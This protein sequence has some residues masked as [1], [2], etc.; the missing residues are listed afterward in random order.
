VQ[1]QLLKDKPGSYI[2]LVD[3]LARLEKSQA[4]RVKAEA[5]RDMVE[6]QRQRADQA[7]KKLKLEREK[8][9]VRTAELF[10]KFYEDKRA[11]EIAEGKGAKTVKMEKLRQLMFPDLEPLDPTPI[12]PT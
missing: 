5:G 11:K 2:L 12:N 8:H 6:I 7:E 3:V 4:D 1:K 9:A 10:L